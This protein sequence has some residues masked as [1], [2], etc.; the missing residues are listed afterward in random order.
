MPFVD[1]VNIT[2]IFL[3]MVGNTVLTHCFFYST[4]AYSRNRVE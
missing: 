1:E 4:Q 3:F 2:A